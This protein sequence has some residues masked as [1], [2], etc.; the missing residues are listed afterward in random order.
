MVIEGN[1]TR[2]MVLVVERCSKIGSALI[3][4]LV[5]RGEQRALVPEPR[6]ADSSHRRNARAVRH[7]GDRSGHDRGRVRRTG[8][9]AL[10]HNGAADKLSSS[11]GQT[12]PCLDVADEALRKTLLGCGLG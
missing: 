2:R 9:E 3:G 12:I 6:R 11:L 5:A 10:S 8:P 4:S 7:I 1:A